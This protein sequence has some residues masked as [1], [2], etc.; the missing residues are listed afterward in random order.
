MPMVE[1]KGEIWG[2]FRS[3]DDECS[4]VCVPPLRNQNSSRESPEKPHV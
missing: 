2:I 1:E 4:R 3:A